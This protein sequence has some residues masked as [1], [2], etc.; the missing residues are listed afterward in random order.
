MWRKQ[1]KLSLAP[2]GISIF[3]VV[4]FVFCLTLGMGARIM[5]FRYDLPQ[6]ENVIAMMQKGEIVI[7][8]NLHPIDIPPEYAHLAYAIL[9]EK[10]KQGV[11][12]VEFLSGSGFPVKHSGWLYRED[13]D[14][15]AWK[16][17]RRWPKI[18]K[19]EPKWYRIGD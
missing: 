17:I 2:L 9:A 3:S 10:S 1:G 8:Q 13:D 7:E 16:D 11:L 19:I 5:K 18:E 14:P 6:Y 15:M 12:T 4:L